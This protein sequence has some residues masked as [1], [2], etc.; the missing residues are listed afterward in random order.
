MHSRRRARDR[1]PISIRD[2]AK[3]SPEVRERSYFAGRATRLD[4]SGG[5]GAC[6]GGGSG[7]AL[8]LIARSGPVPGEQLVD[9]GVRPEIDA[10]PQ[11]L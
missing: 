2:L 7:S 1:E 3:V 5:G 11:R 6:G 4:I 10:E 9:A 8:Q